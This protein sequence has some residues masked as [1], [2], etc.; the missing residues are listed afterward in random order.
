MLPTDPMIR[1]YHVYWVN[2]DPVVGSEMAKRRPAVVVSDDNMNEHLRTVVVCPL[3][4]R[5]HARWPSR[6]QTAIDGRSAEI[7][8]DQIRAV[9]R[10]RIGDTLG[11]ISDDAAESL[12]HVITRMYGG[13]ALTSDTE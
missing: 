9:D 13:L 4:S 6:V 7:A 3:T 12:R 10:T 11:P 8:V 5:L 2:M 1:R